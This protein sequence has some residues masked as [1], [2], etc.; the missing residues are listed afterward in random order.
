MKIY[1]SKVSKISGRKYI[2]V[3][4]AARQIHKDISSRTKR[5]PYIKSTYFDGSKIFIDLFWTH[6]NQKPR[7]DRK[8]RLK[9]YATAIDLLKNSKVKPI[10]KPNPNGKNELV[11]RF[12]GITKD[13]ELYFVQVKQDAKGNKYFMS[14]FS[15][16]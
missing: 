5:S 6:L 3:E 7:A 9:Y 13:G 8:R 1:Q 4:R 12:Y 2:D 11:Y 10:E 14:V 15:P 16:K